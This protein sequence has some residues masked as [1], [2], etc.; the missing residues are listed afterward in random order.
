MLNNNEADG[1]VENNAEKIKITISSTGID[2]IELV[3]QIQ[4]YY[5]PEQ[6]INGVEKNYYLEE[7]KFSGNKPIRTEFNILQYIKQ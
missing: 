7:Y 2:D 3:N 1:L 4:G 6:F 5:H